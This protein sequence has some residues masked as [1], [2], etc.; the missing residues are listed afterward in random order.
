M[1]YHIFNI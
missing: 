1:N